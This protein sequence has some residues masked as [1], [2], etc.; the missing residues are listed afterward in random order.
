MQL[1]QCPFFGISYP[2]TLRMY[3]PCTFPPE[4]DAASSRS[5]YFSFK[6][7]ICQSVKQ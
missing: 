1:L 3:Y 6:Y 7:Q 4:R 5:V 2:L